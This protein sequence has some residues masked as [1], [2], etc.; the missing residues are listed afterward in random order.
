MIRPVDGEDSVH[1]HGRLSWQGHSSIDAIR[2][3]CNLRIAVALQHFPMHFV[4]THFA[5][6]LTA[7]CIHYDFAREPARS[8]I[9]GRAIKAQSALLQ[10]ERSMNRVE[11][12]AERVVN[13]G[14]LRVQLKCHTLRDRSQAGNCKKCDDTQEL[15]APIPSIKSLAS[16]FHRAMQ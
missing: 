10:P 16:V 2:T 4:V 15:G 5:A 8:R 11:R 14:V 3:K 1:P 12:I 13:S 6:T 7:F 9:T